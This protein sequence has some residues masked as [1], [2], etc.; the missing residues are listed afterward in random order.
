MTGVGFDPTGRFVATAS[1]DQ[2]IR[3]WDV[4]TGAALHTL[5]GHARRVNAVA[6]G[7]G[8]LLATACDD[9]SVMLW[10]VRVG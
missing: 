5:I 4:R 7:R 2:T 8:T 6:V 9:G 1:E 10:G 3:V